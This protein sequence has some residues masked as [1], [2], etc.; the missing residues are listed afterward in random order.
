MT[1]L[2]S[3]SVTRVASLS[4]CELKSFVVESL[5]GESPRLTMPRAC[6]AAIR[7]FMALRWV[8]STSGSLPS[9][10][11]ITF[12]SVSGTGSLDVVASLRCSSMTRVASLPSC[13]LK[14]LFVAPGKGN[15]EVV[16]CRPFGSG[17]WSSLSPLL[18][19][20]CGSCCSPCGASGLNT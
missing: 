13:G 17:P 9:S 18:R 14:S 4:P 15:V 3:F 19:M 11:M 6:N 5:Y 1:S 10:L 8:G 16:V 12:S 7:F 20:S 2:R